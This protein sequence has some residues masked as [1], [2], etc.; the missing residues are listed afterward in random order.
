MSLRQET[1]SWGFE[2]VP[3]NVVLPRISASGFNSYSQPNSIDKDVDGEIKYMPGPPGPPG[4]PGDTG[5]TG[6]PGLNGRD[7]GKGGR[8]DRGMNGLNGLRGLKGE[9]EKIT[10]PAVGNYEVVSNILTSRHSVP[11]GKYKAKK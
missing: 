4:P 2:P 10:V 1:N 3:G 5:K 6:M 9:C 11:N 7:G 8:G